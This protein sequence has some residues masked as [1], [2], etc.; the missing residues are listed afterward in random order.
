M[1]VFGVAVY[2]YLHNFQKMNIFCIRIFWQSSPDFF[3]AG[4]YFVKILCNFSRSMV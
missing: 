2:I 4:N 1:Q 3:L